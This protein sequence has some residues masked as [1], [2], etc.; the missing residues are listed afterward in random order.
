MLP[1]LF[2][3]LCAVFVA[4][5]LHA[6]RR[7][8]ARL[9]W[10]AKTA[11][12]A[13]FVA[14]ALAAGALDSAYGLWILLAL[15]LCMAGDVLLI[16][17]GKATFLAGMGA[18]ALGHLAYAGAF[19]S[20][21]AAPSAIFF[22]GAIVMAVFAGASLKWLW[23]HLGDF[24][25]PVAVYTAIIAVMAATSTLAAP[26]GVTAPHWPVIA[27]AFGFAVSDLAVARDRFVSPGFI[28]RVWGLPLYYGAQLLLAGS[29]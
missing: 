28:N 14:T 16:P 23:P 21:G 11:A 9:R 4:V 17:A 5:L 3:L 18:F 15:I 13:A 20:G 25:I 6:E 10:I 27:G 19:V 8:D 1:T 26:P 29:V 24:R 7:D 22:A 12:S 2:A